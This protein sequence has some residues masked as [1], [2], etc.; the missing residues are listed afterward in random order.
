M[1]GRPNPNIFNREEFTLEELLENIKNISKYKSS[2]IKDVTL[3]IPHVF[4]IC[5]MLSG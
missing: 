5:T 3:Y 2:G 4:Y 1:Y